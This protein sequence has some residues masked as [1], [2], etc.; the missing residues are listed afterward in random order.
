MR[1]DS[2]SCLQWHGLVG[3]DAARDL[4]DD[5][6]LLVETLGEVDEGR[7]LCERHAA[8]PRRAV[9]GSPTE[10]HYGN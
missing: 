2:V 6:L 4:A 5:D 3:V 9:Q 7:D 8:G 1:I 10:F